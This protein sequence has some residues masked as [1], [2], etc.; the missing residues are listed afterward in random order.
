MKITVPESNPDIFVCLN[1]L[2]LLLLLLLVL[3]LVVVVVVVVMVVIVVC[4]P[5]CSYACRY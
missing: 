2:L 1:V 4:F 3:V 5:D